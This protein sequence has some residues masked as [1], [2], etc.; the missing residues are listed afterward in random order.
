MLDAMSGTDVVVLQKEASSWTVE[1]AWEIV[2][3]PTVSLEYTRHPDPLL[4]QVSSIS[5]GTIFMQ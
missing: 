2:A 5:D 1:E 3:A 4:N